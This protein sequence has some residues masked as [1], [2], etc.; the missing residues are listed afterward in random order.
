[1]I[2]FFTDIHNGIE[3][4][5][6]TRRC[7]HCCN[8]A[9]QIAD[10]CCHCIIGWILQSCIKISGFLQCEQTTHLI[11]AI[12]FKCCTL[13]NRKYTRLSIARLITGLDAFCF[14]LVIT[15]KFI[16]FL[17]FTRPSYDKHPEH[18]HHHQAYPESSEY[19]RCPSHLS[20]RHM[21]EESL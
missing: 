6:L 21:S 14:N 5:C 4:R 18:H 16:P 20:V 8:S 15:H 13:I 3:V 19:L 7:Q 2:S 11:A 1:M 12:V 9:F 17:C 10:F